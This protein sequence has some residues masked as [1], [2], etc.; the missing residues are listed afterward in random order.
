MRKL[1]SQT[2]VSSSGATPGK[3]RVMDRTRTVVAAGLTAALLSQGIFWAGPP[4]TALAQETG[5]SDRR[6]PGLTVAGRDGRVPTEAPSAL[7]F[8][9][10]VRA[11]APGVQ[12]ASGVQA[13]AP[14]V[15][16]VSPGPQP[17]AVAFQPAA[18]VPVRALP[19]TG[20]GGSAEGGQPWGM[21][22][23]AGAVVA[24]LAYVRATGPE[25]NLHRSRARV[26]D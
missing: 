4:A 17:G 18:Q 1:A 5:Q 20:G 6:G 12:A 19:R 25:P 21:A 10:G 15:R 16:A 7:T 8:A 24:L 2:I 9:P 11:A 26:I 14:G 23:L 22:L 13:A 3:V